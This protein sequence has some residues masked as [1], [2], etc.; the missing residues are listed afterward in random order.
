M[1]PIL[2]PIQC[3]DLIGDIYA[4]GAWR[5]SVFGPAWSGGWKWKVWHVL[6]EDKADSGKTET[7][8]EAREIVERLLMASLGTLHQP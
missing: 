5:G 1:S 7:K 3:N 6:A 2:K 8:R 4:L